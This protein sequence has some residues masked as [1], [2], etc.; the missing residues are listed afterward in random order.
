ML[1]RSEH[2]VVIVRP[3]TIYGP[4]TQH[5]REWWFVKWMLDGRDFIPL[6]YCGKSR[7]HRSSVENIA[8]LIAA[9]I[10]TRTT[11]VLNAADPEAL[12]VMEIGTAIADHLGYSGK[13]LPLDIGDDHGKALVGWTPWSLPKPFVLSTTAA[14]E[15]GYTPVTSYVKAVCPYSDWLKQQDPANWESAFPVLAGY[16]LLLFD[17]AA[18]DRFRL[19][20]HG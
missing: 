18:E 4:Y 1:D 16:P 13:L 15:L 8:A 6:A 5:A 19:T 12:N 20:S 10:E 2:P 14:V 9:V 3:G 7:F 11:C 17:Y